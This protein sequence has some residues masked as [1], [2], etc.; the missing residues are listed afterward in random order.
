MIFKFLIFKF[1]PILLPTVRKIKLLLTNSKEYSLGMFPIRD[2]RYS[3]ILI[4]LQKEMA[5][6]LLDNFV[7]DKQISD[8]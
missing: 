8:L 3:L 1:I 7:A 6:V 5:K 4:I 2:L